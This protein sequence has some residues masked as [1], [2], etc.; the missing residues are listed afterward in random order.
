MT[1]GP[2]RMA[3]CGADKRMSAR[4]RLSSRPPLITCPTGGP[5]RAG[6]NGLLHISSPLQNPLA[7]EIAEVTASA[8]SHSHAWMGRWLDAWFRTFNCCAAYGSPVPPASGHPA[9]ASVGFQVYFVLFAEMTAPNASAVSSLV[10]TGRNPNF[11]TAGTERRSVAE[12]FR[13][14]N[15]RRRGSRKEHAGGR[16]IHA[17][18]SQPRTMDAT[19]TTADSI[20]VF[21]LPIALIIGLAVKHFMSQVT[22]TTN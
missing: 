18:H 20:L 7:Q 4:R 15:D 1:A 11:T 17:Q 22:R 9:A 14:D 19:T 3:V 2:A 6:H 8:Y 21:S 5:C 10:G 16:R 13:R 12:P